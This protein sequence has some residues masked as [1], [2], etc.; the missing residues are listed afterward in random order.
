MQ[1]YIVLMQKL[2]GNVGLLFTNK[3]REEVEGWFGD[4]NEED[5]ASTGFVSVRDVSLPEGPLSQFPHNM[6]QQLRKL[7][8][9]TCLKKGG[10]VAPKS[11]GYIFSF[12]MLQQKNGVKLEQG[13]T[14]S[15][16]L[17]RSRQC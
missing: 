5:F 7:G 14:F 8:L 15:N 3:S 4:Y 1:G 12:Q 13:V 9:P 11:D 17:E 6:E 16:V 2:H 10:L